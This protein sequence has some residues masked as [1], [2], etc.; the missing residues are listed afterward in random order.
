MKQSSG[1]NT[2]RERWVMT[3]VTSLPGRR[4]HLAHE[5]R[6]GSRRA[7]LGADQNVRATHSE[8]CIAA[9]R[10]SRVIGS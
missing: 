5:A 9:I 4:E 2:P 7:R 6:T 1:A 8:R 10:L 3:I